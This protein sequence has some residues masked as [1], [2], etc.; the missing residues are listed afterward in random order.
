MALGRPRPRALASAARTA[1]P[2]GLLI[3]AAALPVTR[4]M[5]LVALVVGAAIAIRRQTPARWVWA[6]P[7]TVAINLCFGLLPA[8]LADPLGRDCTDLDSPPAVRRAAEAA[9]ALDGLA[10]F[11]SL[12]RT[13]RATIGLRWPAAPS[14]GWP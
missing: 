12:L 11:A 3:L 2:L 7:I 5:A 13:R 4:P 9:L 6:A 1:V 8:P 10:L 14:S